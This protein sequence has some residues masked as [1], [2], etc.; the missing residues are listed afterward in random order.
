VFWARA[1]IAEPKIT[2]LAGSLFI[3]FCGRCNQHIYKVH[4]L[5]QYRYKLALEILPLTLIPTTNN[6]R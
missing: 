5:N 3:L 4:P 1:T 2:A 6:C